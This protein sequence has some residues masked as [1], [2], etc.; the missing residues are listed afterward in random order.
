MQIQIAI[1]M[2]RYL[3]I[4]YV[5]LISI[6]FGSIGI[7]CKDKKRDTPTVAPPVKVTVMEVSEGLAT[8]SREY[9][10]T[11]SSAE[12]T[13][14]SFSVPGTITELYGKEGQKVSKGQLLGKVRNGE[15]QNA[16]NIAKAQ[17][18]EAQDGYERLKKLHDANALPDVK[19]VEIQQKLKQAQNMEEMA[20][21]TLN[22]AN[23]HSPVSGTI[24]QKF[25]DVGQ[26]VIAAQPVYE[27]ISTGD[28]TIDIPVSENE[29]GNFRIG[30][31]GKVSFD[32]DNQ[33]AIEGKVTQKSISADPLTRS[34]TVKLS[35]PSQEGKILPG[36]IGKVTFPQSE[37]GKEISKTVILP[38]QAVLLN[39]DN[40]WF[41]WVVNDSVAQ[42]RF[43]TTGELVPSGVE[44][45]S[46]LNPDDCIIVAGMQKVGS[47]TKVI[48]SNSK[49]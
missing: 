15:Y 49:Q 47:G 7:S 16:Y 11:V 41:V 34:Y 35:I 18:D 12:T 37:E 39:E 13:T 20:R 22:D 24:T 14:V 28:L 9:S 29:I 17:L 8:N 6:L 10:G 36:M 44:I 21:R 33:T 40:R 42:R 48:V 1:N 32:I 19:W 2:K 30:E 5:L 38:S 43:V 4:G 45:T 23:L 26:T 46:G 3:D 31:T 25:A 27:I